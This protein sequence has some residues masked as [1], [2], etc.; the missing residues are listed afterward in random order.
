MKLQPYI[1][2]DFEQVSPKPAFYKS[3][4][5]L[6][7][8]KNVNLLTLTAFICNE[9]SK[10]KDNFVFDGFLVK[11]SF[12]AD[13]SYYPDEYT[14]I[15]ST[16]FNTL[17]DACKEEYP[18]QAHNY[19]RSCMSLGLITVDVQPLI[20][21]GSEN[22]IVGWRATVYI[23]KIK[24][25]IIAF[26]EQNQTTVVGTSVVEVRTSLDNFKKS[27]TVYTSNQVYLS[28]SS[29][30][31]DGKEIYFTWLSALNNECKC[32]YSVKDLIPVDENIVNER[33]KEFDNDVKHINT[34]FPSY[35]LDL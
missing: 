5:H 26:F 4:R 18:E 1:N 22:L 24:S 33:L 32:K 8:T 13:K 10:V 29:L 30:K 25:A 35:F 11:E 20:K 27:S 23:D 34:V 17:S 12:L 16:D 2:P 31:L 21:G 7:K 14:S 9:M 6:S 15:Y 3:L 19:M 28:F